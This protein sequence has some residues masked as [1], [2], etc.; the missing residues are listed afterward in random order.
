MNG[1]KFTN[2]F[3]G[4]LQARTC[5]LS[6]F[7]KFGFGIVCHCSHSFALKLGFERIGL[8]EKIV[9]KDEDYMGGDCKGVGMGYM[10]AAYNFGIG[11]ESEG[12]SY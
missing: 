10:P 2:G 8:V 5:S 7:P 9:E 4:R 1:K 12:S 3:L 6:S 11:T